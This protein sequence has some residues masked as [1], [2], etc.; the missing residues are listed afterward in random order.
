LRKRDE[1]GAFS[2][3][4]SGGAHEGAHHALDL[5]GI[6]LNFFDTGGQTGQRALE[7]LPGVNQLV[8]AF[9]LELN[10]ERY[11]H[12][13]RLHGAGDQRR[14]AQRVGAEGDDRHISFRI[15][16][17]RTQ[18][19][20][21]RKIAGGAE[22]ADTDS[23]AFERGGVG[24]VRPRHQR[25]QHAREVEAEISYREAEDGATDDGAG[26]IA[27]VDVAGKQRL[28]SQIGAQRDINQVDAFITVKAALD[29]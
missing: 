20:A 1:A 15:E 27:V 23:L 10:I 14:M 28:D 9:L 18:P 11:R 7:N 13:R 25:V 6:L 19:D 22:G 21:G 4:R 16:T 29:G 12:M 3:Q 8:I 26:A 17:E 24:N 2:F 5:A